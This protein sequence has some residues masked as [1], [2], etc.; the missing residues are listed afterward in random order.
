M[1]T[2][3]GIPIIDTRPDRK[4]GERSEGI[5]KLGESVE[6]AGEKVGEIWLKVRNQNQPKPIVNKEV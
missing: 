5:K 2:I 1:A 3:D 4:P 6:Q